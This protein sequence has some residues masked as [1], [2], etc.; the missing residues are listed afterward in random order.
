MLPTFS[1]PN[2][3][4]VVGHCEDDRI[5]RVKPPPL[6]PTFPNANK[7]PSSAGRCELLAALDTR[8]PKG[9]QKIGNDRVMMETVAVLNMLAPGLPKL[10]T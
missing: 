8:Y 9:T 5:P 3:P 6:H 7:L 2:L 4:A 10:V 1:S